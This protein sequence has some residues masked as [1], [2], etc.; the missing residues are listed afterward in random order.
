MAKIFVLETSLLILQ[1]PCQGSWA[2]GTGPL[3]TRL[4]AQLAPEAVPR[5]PVPCLTSSQT[6]FAACGHVSEPSVMFSYVFGIRSVD[7][8]LYRLWSWK[9]IHYIFW[10]ANWSAAP[11]RPSIHLPCLLSPILP[12]IGKKQSTGGA[13][14]LCMLCCTLNS[15]STTGPI[16]SLKTFDFVWWLPSR[17]LT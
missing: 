4:A 15:D 7:T 11:R 8:R 1:A 9:P 12:W 3:L 5:I 13:G 16:R 2:L 6:E 10:G 14:N 17:Y